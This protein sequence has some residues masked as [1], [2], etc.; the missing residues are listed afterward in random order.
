MNR[1]TTRE[2]LEA[3]LQD[4][5]FPAEKP[6]ILECAE[7]NG[8]DDDTVAALRAIPPV[9]YGSWTELLSAA[10]VESDDDRS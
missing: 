4:L 10:R 7:R 5:D 1:I 2:S 6:R 3:A 9:S 8:A